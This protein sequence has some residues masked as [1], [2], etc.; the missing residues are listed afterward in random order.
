MELFALME[1]LS[2]VGDGVFIAFDLHDTQA[3]PL[4]LSVWNGIEWG[5]ETVEWNSIMH[6]GRWEDTDGIFSINYLTRVEE[7]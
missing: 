1:I 2:R 7:G 4:K 5:E 3:A 6:L